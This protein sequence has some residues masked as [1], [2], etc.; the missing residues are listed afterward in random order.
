VKSLSDLLADMSIN[1]VTTGAR[2]EAS[3]PDNT[4]G[5]MLAHFDSC[6]AVYRAAKVETKK[7]GLQR[8]YITSQASDK[9]DGD[10]DAWN[11]D[12]PDIPVL[13]HNPVTYEASVDA[14]AYFADPAP[15]LRECLS[16]LANGD[17]LPGDDWPIFLLM[18]GEF[19]AHLAVLH[20]RD[21]DVDEMDVQRGARK[22]NNDHLMRYAASF[23]SDEFE[24][25]DGLTMEAARNVF[26]DHVV[27]IVEGSAAP[28]DGWALEDFRKF[29]GKPDRFGP[30][31]KKQ[32]GQNLTQPKL[33][34]WL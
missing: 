9:N 34:D 10:W 32:F 29:L 27:N 14:C 24:T 3:Y 15:A 18:Y 2:I 33:K 1:L 16:G 26:V 8:D 30:R 13:P 19:R 6:V 11:E 21:P 5:T 4:W 25:H 17:E 23:L 31:L 12:N 28:P 20:A 22:N 7:Q